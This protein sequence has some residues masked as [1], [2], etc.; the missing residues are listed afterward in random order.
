MRSQLVR[1]AHAVALARPRADGAMA[2]A[3]LAVTLATTVVSV[4]ILAAG[5]AVGGLVLK[6]LGL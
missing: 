5:W 2:V 6:V 4:A 3:V 1:S